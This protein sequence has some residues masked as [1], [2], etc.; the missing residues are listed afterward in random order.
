MYKHK[1]SARIRDNQNILKVTQ[2]AANASLTCPG[3]ACIAAAR[4]TISSLCEQRTEQ[5]MAHP[6]EFKLSEIRQLESAPGLAFKKK[7][8]Q[9]DSHFQHCRLCLAEATSLLMFWEKPKAVQHYIK[10]RKRFL[11]FLDDIYFLQGHVQLSVTSKI[12]LW[13]LCLSHYLVRSISLES[14]L[15]WSKH[16]SLQSF[17]IGCHLKCKQTCS[18]S[19]HQMRDLSMCKFSLEKRSGQILQTKT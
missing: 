19:S 7:V 18:Y 17:W 13:D 9:N 6:E 5:A 3:T 16:T 8:S 10:L 15:P 11:K 14:A 4:D 1:Q 2:N 12:M